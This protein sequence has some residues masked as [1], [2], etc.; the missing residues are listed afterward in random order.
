[1]NAIFKNL[2]TIQSQKQSS[3]H[4][5]Y[6]IPHTFKLST[7]YLPSLRTSV[8][9][10]SLWLIL[11]FSAACDDATF[12]PTP[13]RTLSGPTL[14]PTDTLV[15]ENPTDVLFDEIEYEGQNDP[16]AAAMAP[17]SALPPLAVGTQP[18]APDL[19]VN[20]EITAFDGVLLPGV[21]FPSVDRRPGVLLL[22]STLDEWGD[23]PSRLHNAGFTLLLMTVR[24]GTPLL[25]FS[26]MMQALSS[27]DADPASLAVIG[28]GR[29]A[30]IAL[31]GCAGDLLCDTMVL[32]SPSGDSALLNAMPAINPRPI[33]LV[34]SED[35]STSYSSIQALQTAASGEV[36]FQPFT[37]AGIGTQML[38]NRPDLGDLIIAWLNRQIG[39][40]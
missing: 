27:G 10:V 30:D 26:L 28:A 1:M 15:L 40:P 22:A 32:L 23:F 20:V 5:S 6:L 37:S 12:T 39:P 9:S 8:F 2:I 17:Q 14:A 24:E 18:G 21:M 3:T 33:M 34:A 29:G 25:D 16:T 7:Q 11:V 35:D 36:L 38:T 4:T 31:L 19:P 13:A